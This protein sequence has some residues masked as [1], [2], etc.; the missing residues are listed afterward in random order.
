MKPH[1]LVVCLLVLLAIRCSLLGSEPAD[2]TIIASVTSVQYSG[3]PSED[4]FTVNMIIHAPSNLL[5]ARMT[6]ATTSATRS[7]LRKKYPVGGL[8]SFGI[9]SF[10][11][12]KLFLQLQSTQSVERQID[13]G[14]SPARISQG[15][16][17]VSFVPSDLTSPPKP[18]IA[19]P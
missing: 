12:L 5:G 13:S 1:P 16:P 3:S 15:T 18:Y 8:V 19:A 9:P 4:S 10:L 2:T 7:E 11:V 6:M 14:I 17:I